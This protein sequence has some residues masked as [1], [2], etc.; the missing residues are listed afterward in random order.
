M[1]R[2]MIEQLVQKHEG[3]RS[4]TYLDTRGNPTNGVGFNLNSSEARDICDHYGIDLADLKDGKVTLTETQ[5]DEI[6]SF[7]LSEVIIQ[8]RHLLPN[9]DAMP[10]G[11]Q[12]VVCDLIFNMGVTRFSKFVSTIG[13]LKAGN[14]KQ[15]AADLTNS[16]WFHQV[17]HRGTDNVGILEKEV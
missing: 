8:A 4:V 17:G 12:A 15:A 1:N 14:W 16:L 13:Q 6:F 11:V 3:R 5:I 10:D 2:Q 7:Q 9:Y